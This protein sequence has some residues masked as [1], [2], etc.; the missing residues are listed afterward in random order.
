MIPASAVD[1]LLAAYPAVASM[2]AA[3]RDEVLARHAVFAEVPAGAPLFDEGAPCRGFPLVLG[4]EVR[5]ARGAPQGR[6]LELYRVAPGEVCVVSAS[7]LFGTRMLQAHG[8]ASAPTQLVLVDPAG[9]DRWCTHAPF[10]TFVFGVFAERLADLMGLVEAVAFQRLDRRLAA[11]LLGHGAVLAT[12]HQTLA[13]ELGTVRE[14]VTR[15]LRRFERAGWLALGRERIEIRDAA[16]LRRLSAGD[17][18]A[19]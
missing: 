17:G 9:F 10:R 8:V 13:D 2:P 4:G 16:A 14:I 3:L 1:A 19:M 5:V 12:T 15:L 6:A 11:A 7:C 18:A